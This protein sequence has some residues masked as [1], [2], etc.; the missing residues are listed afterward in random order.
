[1]DFKIKFRAFRQSDEIFINKLREDDEREN[2][3]GGM[4]RYISLDREAKWVNDIIMGDSQT[5]IYLAITE[6]GSEEIIGYTSISDIDYRNGT[7]F[8]SGIK[9]GR[10]Y[11]GKGY[12]LQT[13]LL[14]INY[15]FTELRMVRCIGICQ[16]DH[17]AAMNLMLKTGYKKEGLM[18]KRLFKNGKH[19][20]QWLLSITDDDYVNVKK[21]FSL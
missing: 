20:S 15:V 10:Q 11:S 16:E 14:I 1:M 13:A 21:N 17:V 6:I 12:G 8:W 7:C 5:I 19:I 3:V 2:K 4:K 9:L 18:R